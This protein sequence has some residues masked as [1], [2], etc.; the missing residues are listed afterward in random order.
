M[1]KTP[2]GTIHRTVYDGLG[3][4]VS[5]WVGTNDTGATNADP[6]GGGASGNNMVKVTENQY[7]GGGVGDGNLTQTTQ[8]PGGGAADRV[9]QFSY[10]WRDRLVASKGGVQGSEG[11]DVQRPISYVEY[12]N[13]GQVVAS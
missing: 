11:T 9:S 4:A 8:I 6:T 13:L 3:R 2:T 12:D 10:D 5:E 1:T 7:D